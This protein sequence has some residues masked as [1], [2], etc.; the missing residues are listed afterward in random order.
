MQ[1]AVIPQIIE[2]LENVRGRKQMYFRPVDLEALLNFLA[3]FNVSVSLLGNLDWPDYQAHREAY[4]KRNWEYTAGG[5]RKAAEEM[6]KR[7]MTE[8]NILDE[9]LLLEI[10]AWR[11]MLE[12]FDD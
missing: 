7:G 8:E 6:R 11:W 10:E 9:V 4:R 2:R 5:A 3:G 1:Q 12:R